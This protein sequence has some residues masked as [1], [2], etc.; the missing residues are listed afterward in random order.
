MSEVL[1]QRLVGTL[2]VLLVVIIS[3]FLLVKNANDKA[4]V[5]NAQVVPV[6]NPKIE[7]V[8]DNVFVDELEKL[9]DP[10]NMGNIIS[11]EVKGLGSKESIIKGVPPKPQNLATKKPTIEKVKAS[12]VKVAKPTKETA[13]I[14]KL[15][16]KKINK[17]E[18]LIQLASFSVRGKAQALKVKVKAL[19]YKS[20]IVPIKNSEGRTFY[21]LRVGPESDEKIVN[22]IVS[23]VKKHLKLTPQ[24]IKM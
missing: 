12:I 6:S 19:G 4:D 17:P 15:K 1:K 3:A 7:T 18:W 21:R 24:I 11:S 2:L 14:S 10:H 8:D 23:K 16:K 5:Q 13:P 22:S 9:I 20:S